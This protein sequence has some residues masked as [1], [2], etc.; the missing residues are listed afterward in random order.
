M[1]VLFTGGGTGG[2]IYP[3]LAVAQLLRRR[4][5]QADILFVGTE[6]GLEQDLVPKA[7][8]ALK[9]I[10]SA[11][12]RRRLTLANL[13]TLVQNLRGFGQAL[14]IIRRFRP[15]VVLGTGGYVT[16]PVV[17]AA[18]LQGVPVVLHEQNA[19]PGLANRWLS[20]FA[21][22]VAVSYADSA[23]YFPR[24]KVLVSG[25]PVREAVWRRTREEGR[26]NLEI[27]ADARLVLVFGGSRGARPVTEAAVAAAP[28]LLSQPGN[29]L[30]VVTGSG[31][32][33]TIEE[34][35]R[36][37]GIQRSGKG[38][39]L[40]RPYLY[41]MEDALAAADVVV[42]RAGATTIAEITARGIPA[43]LVPSPYVTANHQEFNARL[44]VRRGAALM[45]R[46]KELSGERLA[47]AIE[48]LL[49]RPDERARMAAAAGALGK[50]EAAETIADEIERLARRK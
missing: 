33:A 41:N 20:R 5:S 14:A 21:R 12:L 3:A 28:V 27:P 26:Q 17:M 13:S 9:A 1:R 16:V 11:G 47:R 50:R 31:D 37:L 44:L 24:R 4:D 30:L 8:F 38:K 10:H 19:L 42:T 40:L 22:R 32:F 45:I 6:R 18:F 46:E 15:D 36:C 23:R 39:M 34:K 35:V 48:D 43:I 2:H 25:N 7:G 29:M 49:A